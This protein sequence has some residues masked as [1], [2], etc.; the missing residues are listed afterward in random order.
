MGS[1]KAWI[2]WAFLLA[3]SC[4]S[5]RAAVSV[6][7]LTEP[8]EAWKPIEFRVEGI[9]S[10]SNPFDNE[11]IQV[12]ATFR[13]PTGHGAL[14][15]GHAAVGRGASAGIPVAPSLGSPK[16]T[17]LTPGGYRRSFGQQTGLRT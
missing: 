8:V 1:A 17:H 4:G 12:D 13:E 15:S 5:G 9:P 6:V 11:E 10:V 3:G 7:P 16:P 2:V 14:R